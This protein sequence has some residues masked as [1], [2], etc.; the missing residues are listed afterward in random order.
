MNRLAGFKD[1]LPVRFGDAN[2]I[3][4][5]QVI[6]DAT[7]DSGGGMQLVSF[8]LEHDIMKLSEE[9][10]AVQNIWAQMPGFAWN[11][12]TLAAKPTARVLLERGDQPSLE[13]N[14]PMLVDGRFGSGTVLYFGFQGTW[15]WRQ[16]G[17]QAQYFN[18]FWIQT[19]RYLIEHRSLQGNRRGFVDADRT[20]YELGSSVLLLANLV[21][22]EFKP[23]QDESINAI[24]TDEDGRQQKI[25]LQRVPGQEGKYETNF[26]ATRVG[27]FTVALDMATDADKNLFEPATFRVTPP[28]IETSATWRNEKLLR[29]IAE[30]SGG[31]YFSIENLDQ[32]AAVLPDLESRIEFDSPPQPLWDL[33]RWLRGLAFLF[34]VLLLTIEWALR[35]WYKLL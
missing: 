24:V 35:K 15:R 30:Q 9:T 31:K 13:G 8:N 4:A 25:S 17:L 7:G 22:E 18:S 34:P 19:I 29:D 10:A 16:V 20:E 2:A 27:S 26:K 5:S 1:I 11:F 6:A 32:V 3:A 21:N 12:P 28:T 33:N 14:Q 23:A